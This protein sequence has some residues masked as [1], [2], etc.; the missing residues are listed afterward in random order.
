[1]QREGSEKEL[2]EITTDEAVGV[3]MAL[4]QPVHVERDVWE[5]ARVSQS[6]SEGRCIHGG[7]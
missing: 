3:A 1:M 7:K 5:S 2:I 4:G 6:V